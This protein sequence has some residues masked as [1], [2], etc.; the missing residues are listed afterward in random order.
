MLC[1]S[2]TMPPFRPSLNEPTIHTG[3]PPSRAICDTTY[4]QTFFS[5]WLFLDCLTLKMEAK[6]S[7]RI[8]GNAHPSLQC[9]SPEYLNLQY[10][11]YRNDKTSKITFLTCTHNDK[12]LSVFLNIKQTV[13]IYICFDVNVFNN[14]LP[15]AYIMKI[16]I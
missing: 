14:V 3:L 1:L 5:T 10:Q 8:F 13:P 12:K 16:Q 15:T 6:S 11:C 7:F 9:H 2:G 4:M